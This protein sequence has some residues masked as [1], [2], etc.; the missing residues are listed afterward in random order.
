LLARDIARRNNELASAEA[1]DYFNKSAAPHAFFP[2]QL[3]L[4]DKHSF[5]AKN[6]KL[7][8][9]WSDPKGEYNI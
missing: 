2:D 7:A 6:K 8:P 9:K 1:Q 4:L 5:L 3:V